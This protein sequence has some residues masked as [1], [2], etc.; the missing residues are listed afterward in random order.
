MGYL[1]GE[2]TITAA[3]GDE[4]AE[5]ALRVVQHADGEEVA[6]RARKMLLSTGSRPLRFGAIPFDDVRVF[7][8]DSVNGLDFLPRSV[9]IV[10]SGISASFGH[11]HPTRP[12]APPHTHTRARP[13]LRASC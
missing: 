11:A 1:Q 6:I 8:S 3:A 9:V 10:G 2:A 12:R 4:A 7:D 5:H 13:P